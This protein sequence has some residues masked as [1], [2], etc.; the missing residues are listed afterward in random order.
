MCGGSSSR[1]GVLKGPRWAPQAGGD[2]LDRS[3]RVD[4]HPLVGLHQRREVRPV[5]VGGVEDVRHVAQIR[6]LALG[7]PGI[8]EVDAHLPDGSRGLAAA[9]R[10]PDRPPAL[11]PL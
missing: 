6:Q 10:E 9:T 5:L 7:V 2:G 3:Q 1:A 4:E 8:E 11:Q